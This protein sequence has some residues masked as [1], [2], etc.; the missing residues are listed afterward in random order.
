MNS[1]AARWEKRYQREKKSRKAAEDL[2]EKK[3]SELFEANERLKGLLD[4]QSLLVEEKTRELQAALVVAKDANEHKSLFLANMSHEIR[5]PM[6]AIIGLSH[7]ALENELD[8]QQ[9]S[10]LHKIQLSAK[11][12]LGIIN[13]ILDFSKIEAGKMNIELISFDLDEVLSDLFEI[14]QVKAQEKGIS[15]TLNRDF[16]FSSHVFSDPVRINQ[17]LTNLVSNA[18]KFTDQGSVSIDIDAIRNEKE[19]CL[20]IVVED[21]G[22]GITPEQKKQLFSPFTQ[23]DSSTTRQFGGSGLGLSITRKLTELLG[24]TI[25][26]ESVFEQGTKVTVTLPLQLDNNNLKC[27][28]YL[29]GKTCL[30]IGENDNSLINLLQHFGL[31]TK[32]EPYCKDSIQKVESLL[33]HEIVDCIIISPSKNSEI[34]ITDYLLTLRNQ[35]P[36]VIV[37]PCVLITGMREANIITEQ[38]DHYNIHAISELITPSSI[39]DLLSEILQPNINPEPVKKN[40]AS[41]HGI[42]DILGTRVLLV[43][44]NPLNTEVAKGMLERMGLITVCAE[45]GQEALNL[46]EKS[47]FDVVLMDLQMP[48]MDGFETITH[49]RNNPKYSKLPVIA[50]TA[51]AMTGDKE[52]SLAAGMNDHITKPIDVN[53]LEKTLFRWAPEQ[54]LKRKSSLPTSSAIPLLCDN[55]PGLN[56]KSSLPRVSGDLNLYFSL[57]DQY[58]LKYPDLT[59]QVADLIKSNRLSDLHIL[60]HSVKGVFANLGAFELE[61]TCATLEHFKTSPNDGKAIV[62]KLS[63]ELETVR[64]TLDQLKC[65]PSVPSEGH[66]SG[67]MNSSEFTHLLTKLEQLLQSGDI[68]AIITATRLREVTAKGKEA[69]FKGLESL[70]NDFE[71][72]AALKALQCLKLTITDTK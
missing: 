2:L 28:N 55:A 66:H 11:N 44:D 10:Y 57:W 48:I 5:T 70:I 16:S 13:D 31:C 3:A 65:S 47:T 36:E 64:M 19:A 22:I 51:H 53:E 67:S 23:G 20:N 25:Y 8:Q 21:T 34:D 63:I 32:I 72:E 15:F 54:S 56:L 58:F 12:L 45:N 52:K 43:E 42:E 35:V 6:N 62:E 17:I 38:N 1:E 29:K 9:Q 68:E 26:L 30:T 18:I 40:R 61:Q 7:L 37:I 71:F 60:S 39:F 27:S 14:Q 4:F 50:L 33:L 24:G 41:L 46:L 59:D 69:E 49:I